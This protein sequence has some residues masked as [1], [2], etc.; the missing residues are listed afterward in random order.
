ML[1][2]ISAQQLEEPEAGCKLF[3]FMYGRKRSPNHMYTM[4]RLMQVG[5]LKGSRVNARDSLSIQ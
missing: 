1:E 5:G 3:E 4:S 2:C